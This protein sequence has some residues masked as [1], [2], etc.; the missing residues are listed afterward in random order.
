MVQWTISSNERRELGRAAGVRYRTVM[1]P[2]DFIRANSVLTAPPL[3]PELQL[4]LAT[5][6]VPLWRKTEEELHAMGVPPPFWAFAWAG[7]QALA[8]YILD[9]PEIVRG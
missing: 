1:N 7:G 3:V 4:Y 5:E 8:R 6:I 2:E 9:H